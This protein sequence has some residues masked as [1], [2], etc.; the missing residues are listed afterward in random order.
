MVF[1]FELLNQTLFLTRIDCRLPGDSFISKAKYLFEWRVEKKEK[2]FRFPKM[3]QL[4]AK[5]IQNE[6]F[7]FRE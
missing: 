3:S 2:L 6:P 5:M 1:D 7:D 4:N